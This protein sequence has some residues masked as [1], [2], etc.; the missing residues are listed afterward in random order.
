MNTP[1]LSVIVPAYNEA[2]HL[3]DVIAKMARTLVESGLNYEIC[4]V[5]NGSKDGTDTVI[6]KLKKDQPRITSVT[7]KENQ[8]Y[9]GGILAG[10]ASA[11]GQVLCWTHADGQA[12]PQAIVRLF[13]RMRAE[14]RELAMAVRV[15]RRE[16]MWRKVQG[17]VYFRLFQL[18]F[19]SPYRDI[20][21]TPKLLTSWAARALN[22]KSR[23]WFL[24]P[25]FVIKSLRL[26]MPIC[27]VETIW[28]SRRSGSTRA[29]LL[30]GLGMLKTM[31]LYRI[32]VK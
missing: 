1:E 20:N 3:E 32:G 31:I 15:V 17:N 9:G 2:V 27:E 5:N 14:G 28:N 8:G 13:E 12:D 21:G 16:S 10:L 25:E 11:R 23:D 29:H 26:K 6:E 18:F 24:E 30:T 7:L 19:R 4:I 22:L